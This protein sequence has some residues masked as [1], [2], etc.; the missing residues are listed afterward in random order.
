[1]K[2]A[3]TLAALLVTVTQG[4]HAQKTQSPAGEQQQAAKTGQATKTGQAKKTGQASK[5]LADKAKSPGSKKDWDAAYEQLLRN[6]PDVRRKIKNGD[7][8]KA[9]VIAWMKGQTG[10][11]KEPSNEKL[12]TTRSWTSSKP[13]SASWSQTED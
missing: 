13:D 7:A 2:T 12:I 6:D 8:T 10:G 4:A 5:A 9:E 3:I 11:K 1:M